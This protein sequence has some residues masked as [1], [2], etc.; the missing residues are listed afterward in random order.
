M[1]YHF[2]DPDAPIDQLR[3]LLIAYMR[4]VLDGLAAG[5]ADRITML[6][7]IRLAETNDDYC[8]SQ[9]RQAVKTARKYG[10]RIEISKH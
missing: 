4:E 2:I 6:E 3:P 7:I 5:S 8:R 9:A 1:D 10:Q